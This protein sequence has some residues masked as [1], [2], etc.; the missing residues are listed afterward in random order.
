MAIE[1]GFALAQIL[2]H[3]PSSDLEGAL[4]LFQDLRKPRTDKVTQTSYEAGK[5]ASCAIPEETWAEN[6]KPETIRDRMKWIME[7]DLFGDIRNRLLAI[8]KSESEENE[9][10]KDANGIEVAV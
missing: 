3:W 7:Y 9:N 4:Q 2:Q 10:K 6:F 5:L 1:S 8:E